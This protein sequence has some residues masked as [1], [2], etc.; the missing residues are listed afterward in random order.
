[1][2]L[3]YAEATHQGAFLH[4][5]PLATALLIGGGLVTT[6]PLLLFGSAAQ[7]IPLALI[8]ILQYIN[9]TLQFLLGTLV[10]HEP[11]SLPRLI[12]FSLV[13]VALLLFGAEGFFA[14]R[15]QQAA[16]AAN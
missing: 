13:W 14:L 6:V 7:R 15:A 11:F 8:G 12:G 10:Y 5:G 16:A 1:L 2:Y 4:T 9:P 3:V